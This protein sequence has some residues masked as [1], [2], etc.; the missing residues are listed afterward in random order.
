MAN[1]IT[2]SFRAIWYALTGRVPKHTDR[3]MDNPE[4]VRDAYE[5]IIRFKREKIQRYKNAIGQLIALIEQKKLSLKKLTEEVDDLEKM[6][7]GAIAKAKSIA[8]ELQKEGTL[9]EEIEQHPVYVL[10]INSYNGYHSTLEEKNAQVIKLE[11][12]IKRAQEEIESFI[13]E[14]ASLHRDLD[15]I[16]KEQ[17]EAVADLVEARERRDIAEIL[18]GIK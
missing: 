17:S 5:F 9:A 1:G 18:A 14:L 16:K 15:R 3:L 11:Q 12:K 13:L 7:A 4:A 8:A 6:K 10:H 2:R